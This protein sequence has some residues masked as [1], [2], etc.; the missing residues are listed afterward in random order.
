MKIVIVLLL[1]IVF[2]RSVRIL[3]GIFIFFTF[4]FI[5]GHALYVKSLQRQIGRFTSQQPG[6]K[7]AFRPGDKP[8]IKRV[9]AC[10]CFWRVVEATFLRWLRKYGVFLFPE[11][12]VLLAPNLARPRPAAPPGAPT[13]P[14]RGMFGFWIRQINVQNSC[15][16]CAE[17]ARGAVCFQ[18]DR[19]V[20]T[21]FCPASPRP[22]VR[23]APCRPDPP[24]VCPCFG[25][26][27]LRIRQMTVYAYR[28][29]AYAFEPPNAEAPMWAA[30]GLPI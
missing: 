10:S 1:V 19:N 13:R 2:R 29:A 11:R 15:L 24:V 14:A 5:S 12:I 6:R 4:I 16:Q 27:R 26:E 3:L 28:R 7:S 21:L 20:G 9:F 17:R 18:G 23:P 25:F 8:V 30:Y 22:A